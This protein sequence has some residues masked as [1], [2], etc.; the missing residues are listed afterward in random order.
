CAL[1]NLGIDADLL[2]AKEV[3][4]D[5]PRDDQLLRLAFRDA[6][7][8]LAA[9]RAYVALQIADARLPRVMADDVADRFF[10]ELDLL[11]FQAVLIDLPRNQVALRDVELLVLG[12]TLKL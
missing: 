8:F 1:R 5:L 9:D 10:R 3:F 12:V 6:P 2:T 11:R 7:R 4:N